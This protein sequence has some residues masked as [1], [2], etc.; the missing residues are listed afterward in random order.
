MYTWRSMKVINQDVRRVL[1]F[2]HYE[3]PL[4]RPGFT[5]LVSSWPPADTTVVRPST[6]LCIG[7]PRTTQVTVELQPS[8]PFPPNT[9]T[10][11][12]THTPSHTISQPLFVKIGSFQK[13]YVNR[14][15]AC[16]LTIRSAV[17]I[18]Q[19]IKGIISLA[20][21]CVTQRYTRIQHRPYASWIHSTSVYSLLQLRW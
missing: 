2:E 14:S 7:L 18:D 10:H 16:T 11:T 13:Y 15:C 21:K 12:H 3:N 19:Q 4:T 17:H 5:T 20:A 6:C 9:H 8:T 1:A